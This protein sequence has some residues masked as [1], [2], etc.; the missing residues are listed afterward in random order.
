MSEKSDDLTLASA[1]GLGDRKAFECLVSRHYA[2]MYKIAFKWCGNQADAQDI[3]QNAC[4][5]LA[6]SIA[7]FRGEAAF[8]TWLYRLVINTAKD[9]QR[10]QPVSEPETE[11]EKPAETKDFWHC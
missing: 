3:T 8:T 9:W 2:T 7:S 6:R 1:A 10:Q 4:L 11:I 5:K